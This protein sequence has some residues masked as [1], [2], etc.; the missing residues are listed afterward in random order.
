MKCYHRDVRLP[1]E[2]LARASKRVALKYSHHALR[3]IVDDRY[4][5]KYGV[6]QNLPRHNQAF[7]IKAEQVIEVYVDDAAQVEKVLVRAPVDSKRDICMV[8]DS[9]GLV[10]TVWQNEAGDLHGTLDRSKYVA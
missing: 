6:P 1:A 10:R 5:R 8:I 9:R 4:S 2:V 3:A 7:E